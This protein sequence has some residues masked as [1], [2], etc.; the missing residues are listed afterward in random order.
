MTKYT[1]YQ[2]HFLN[3]LIKDC[4]TFRL[5]EKEAMNYVRIRFGERISP[6]TYYIR[7]SKL[8]SDT[9]ANIWLSNFTKIGFLIKHKKLLEDV[10]LVLEESLHQLYMELQCQNRNELLIIKL[11]N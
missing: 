2:S 11:K 4:M 1:R 6:K 7:K 5:N 9:S 10:D 8:Q 3:E